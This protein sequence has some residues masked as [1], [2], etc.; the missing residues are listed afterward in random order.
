MIIRPSSIGT[1]CEC[2]AKYYFMAIE[3]VA[4]SKPIAFAFGT[5]VHKA[6]ETNY[7][8]KVDSETDLPEEQI[9][10]VFSDTYDKE[11]TDCEK[12]DFQEV[13]E[14]QLKDRG[15][16]LLTKYHAEVSPRIMPAIVEERINI[17]I[18]GINDEDDEGVTLSGQIDLIDRKYN[19]IDTKRQARP[20]RA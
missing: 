8:Q 15:T 10:D 7:S 19:L 11:I 1:F 12:E 17:K 16:A 5:S 18:K 20:P 9:L 14:G 3:K 2:G 4:V 6:L 13:K